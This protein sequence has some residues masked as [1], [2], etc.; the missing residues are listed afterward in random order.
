MKKDVLTVAA[1]VLIAETIILGIKAGTAIA[2]GW[3][4]KR[5]VEKEME[6]V[7]EG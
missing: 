7:L 3:W 6:A 1:G 4:A 5:K 2:T